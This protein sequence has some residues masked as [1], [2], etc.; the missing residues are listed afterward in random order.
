MRAV[1]PEVRLVAPRPDVLG[2]QGIPR[3]RMWRRCDDPL[4][5]EDVHSIRSVIGMEDTDLPRCR[6]SFRRLG[7]DDAKI[8]TVDLQGDL[9]LGESNKLVTPR[10]L[11]SHSVEPFDPIH[12]TSVSPSRREGISARHNDLPPR[13]RVQAAVPRKP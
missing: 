13:V 4:L 9:R 11:A 7:I 10:V 3:V 6:R 12:S 5:D 1:I 8:E 2:H